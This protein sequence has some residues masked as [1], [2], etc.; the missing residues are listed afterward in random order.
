MAYNRLPEDTGPLIE[1]QTSIAFTGNIALNPNALT[2][3][4]HSE[5]LYS[6][7]LL[8]I[9]YN[10]GDPVVDAS[11]PTIRWKNGELSNDSGGN[12]RPL[13]VPRDANGI[14]FMEYNRP[15]N[16]YKF[17]GTKHRAGSQLFQLEVITPNGNLLNTTIIRLRLLC[18]YY[19]P[20]SMMFDMSRLSTIL[21]A[22]T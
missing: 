13:V 19:Q 9:G 4:S 8:E 5:A 7:D 21:N 17:N 3:T 1:F 12:N 10:T 20:Q 6:I 18:K 11:L 15:V 14:H 22:P 2:L 16:I